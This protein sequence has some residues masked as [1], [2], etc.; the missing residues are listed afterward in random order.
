MTW[1]GA[2]IETQRIIN[3]RVCDG[4]IGAR[5]LGKELLKDIDAATALGA[6]ATTPLNLSKRLRPGVENVA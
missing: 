6:G 3:R 2:A 4:V 5:P 1:T